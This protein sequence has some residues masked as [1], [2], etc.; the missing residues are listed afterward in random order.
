MKKSADG[1][2][3][4]LEAEEKAGLA[5]LSWL[6]EFNV[7]IY[8]AC[9]DSAMNH[10]KMRLLARNTE[11][12]FLTTKEVDHHRRRFAFGPVLSLY[13]RIENELKTVW[14][15]KIWPDPQDPSYGCVFRSIRP[16]VPEHSGR[17]FRSLRPGSERSDAGVFL[18]A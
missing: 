5:A 3:I 9:V 6:S 12:E 18:L 10:A 16:G 14:K 13:S 4:L 17:L 2:Q 1:Q 15:Q 8:K 7:P 11:F